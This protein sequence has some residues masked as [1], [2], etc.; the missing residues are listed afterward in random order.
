[1]QSKRITS[2]CDQCGAAFR[3]WVIRPRRYCGNVCAKAARADSRP[4]PERLMATGQRTGTGCL[5]WTAGCHKPGYGAIK[6]Q[7]R[8]LKVHRVSYETFVG[9]IPDGHQVQHLCEH[10]YAPGDFTYRR[11]FEPT[12]LTTGTH[13]A[14]MQAMVESGRVATGD[15]NARSRHPERTARGERVPLAKLTAEQVATI[16]QRRS[17]GEKEIAIARE[18]GL[19]VSTIGRIMRRETWK[20]VL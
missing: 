10:H 19:N 9:P 6:L 12:H 17:S 2:T 3:F 14:N 4:L 5:L 1:M 18:Y 11:C 13:P 15:R 8:Q 7:G 16:R 20:H